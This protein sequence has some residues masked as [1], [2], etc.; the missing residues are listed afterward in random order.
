[1]LLIYD[2][3]KRR[4]PDALVSKRELSTQTNKFTLNTTCNKNR[5]A[6]LLPSPVFLIWLY[7]DAVNGSRC[8]SSSSFWGRLRG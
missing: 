5:R 3:R 1:M 7:V 8:A 4:N 6:L 2:R